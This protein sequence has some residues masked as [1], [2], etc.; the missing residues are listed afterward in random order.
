MTRIEDRLYR[1]AIVCM[2]VFIFAGSESARADGPASSVVVEGVV[3]IEGRGIAGVEIYSDG[4][5]LGTTDQSGVFSIAVPAGSPVHLA[6]RREG[7][8]EKTVITTPGH[9]RLAVT[10]R[11]WPHVDESITVTARREFTL[12]QREA[13][14][15]KV[16]RAELATTPA[17]SAAGA[18]ERVAGVSTVPDNGVTDEVFIRGMEPR[19]TSTMIDGERIPGT[20]GDDRTAALLFFP[21]GLLETVEVQTTFTPEMDG[22]AIGGSVNLLTRKAPVGGVTTIRIG[23]GRGDQAG[24]ERLE[25]GVVWGRRAV[26]DK[27]GVILSVDGDGGDQGVDRVDRDYVD[28]ELVRMELRDLGIERS[29]IGGLLRL[30]YAPSLKTDLSFK[31]L[32]TEFSET[33]IQRRAS[34]NAEE[35]VI[36]RDLRIGDSDRTITSVDLSGLHV[37]S[38]PE[39]IGYRFGYFHS[40]EDV[41]ERVDATFILEDAELVSERGAIVPVD[42][43][44]EEFVLD[45]IG[46]ETHR[47]ED[48]NGHAGLDLAIPFELT[49]RTGELRAG[50]K[51]R[52]KDKTQRTRLTTFASDE[53]D[54]FL[55]EVLDRRYENEIIAGVRALGPVPEEGSATT[56]ID[57]FELEAERSLEAEASNYDASEDSYAG[58]ALVETELGTR[59]MILAGLRYERTDTTYE[60]L[61]LAVAEVD[62]EEIPVLDP[63]RGDNDYDVWMPA[64]LLSVELSGGM[65]LK[66]G[67]SRTFARP[68]FIHVIPFSQIDREDQEVERGNPDLHLTRSW[69]L[70]LSLNWSRSSRIGAS[71]APYYKLIDDFIYE[72]RG[73]IVVGDEIF[74]LIEPR[75]GDDARV[76]GIDLTFRRGPEPGPSWRAGLFCELDVSWSESRAKIP[77]RPG[78]TLSLPGHAKVTGDLVL[79]LASDRLDVR[80][81]GSY[82]GDRLLEVGES[83][84]YDLYSKNR[85]GL[86]AFAGVRISPRTE[87]FIRGTNLTDEP[88]ELF[89]GSSSRSS[90]LEFS[91]RTVAIGLRY[92]D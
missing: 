73:E 63:T 57:R 71:A 84:L 7:F 33:A 1:I 38:G 89:E 34:F 39:R 91:G 5:R 48:E 68:D 30:D 87:I 69:N 65:N 50:L 41:P 17:L 43:E 49:G 32:A 88:L 23:A 28:A 16:G 24:E 83:R 42:E 77:S 86:D 46:R 11:P 20:D 80:V 79:G 64:I 76:Y 29:R 52:R 90:Q 9:G 13:A 92:G 66:G 56:L 55:T 45:E 74:R 72:G 35:G 8:F 6:F 54:I 12:I 21:V 59:T 14:V 58:Y 15:E 36:L 3:T 60:G 40:R 81:I 18:I 31:A 44:I 2:V 51:L 19:L 53:A 75:N 10:L 70:D 47:A 61:E 25:A 85:L 67:V 4:A 62:G 26:D 78:E 82:V 37:L 27:L 22:D